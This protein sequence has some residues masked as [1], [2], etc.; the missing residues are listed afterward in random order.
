MRSENGPARGVDLVVVRAPSV[1]SIGCRT[2]FVLGIGADTEESRTRA[3]VRLSDAAA[4]GLASRTES[5]AEEP[6][7]PGRLNRGRHLTTR[8]QGEEVLPIYADRRRAGRGSA[9]PE[10]NIA[11]NAGTAREGHSGLC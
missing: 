1:E 8:R 10:R 4:R 3:L 9:S 7:E 6:R 5:F 2:R 11:R